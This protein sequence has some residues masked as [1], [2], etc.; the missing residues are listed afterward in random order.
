[1]DI[2][3]KGDRSPFN[4]HDTGFCT[5]PLF[6]CVAEYEFILGYLMFIVGSASRTDHVLITAA[7]YIQ[8]ER[9]RKTFSENIIFR[10]VQY[11]LLP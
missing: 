7:E 4:P 10:R 2:V 1:M 3:Q 11:D 9:L 8:D 6:R 5:E